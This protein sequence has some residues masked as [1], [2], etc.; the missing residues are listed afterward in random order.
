MNYEQ[1]KLFAENLNQALVSI[2]QA[3]ETAGMEEEDIEDLSDSWE[4]VVEVY[5]RNIGPHPHN[6]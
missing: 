3:L 5:E 2:S 4:K 1:E 6:D